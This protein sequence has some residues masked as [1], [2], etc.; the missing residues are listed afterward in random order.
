MTCLITSSPGLFLLLFKARIVTTS[1]NCARSSY[2]RS[3]ASFFPFLATLAPE[4]LLF[5]WPGIE[6]LHMLDR[7]LMLH[8]LQT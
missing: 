8:L 2:A 3:V 1:M 5:V 4:Q 6:L 7:F